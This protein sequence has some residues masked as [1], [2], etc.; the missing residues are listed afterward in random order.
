[1]AMDYRVDYQII[2]TAAKRARCRVNDMLALAPKNDPFYVGAPASVVKAQWFAGIYN[3]RFRDTQGA[4]LRRI[5]YRLVVEGDAT[6]A[7]GTPYEN[8]EQCWDYLNDASKAARY[9]GLVDADD[10]VDRRNPDP[11]IS[12]TGGGDVSVPVVY[13]DTPDWSLPSLPTRFELPSPGVQVYGYEYVPDNQPYLVEVWIEKT[14]QNDILAPLCR[15]LGANL[16]TSAGYQ[17]V[18]AALNLIRRAVSAD[19]PARVF[20]VSDFDPAGLHMPVS[21]ARQV[22]FW[23]QRRGLSL[24]IKLTPLALTRAQ[25]DEHGLPRT[26][27]KETD[28]RREGFELNHGTGA[29]ELDALEALRPGELEAL[30]RRAIA[31]Y[32]DFA[33][34]DRLL[35]S[36]AEAKTAA[37]E[38]W[39]N[40]YADYQAEKDAIETEVRATLERYQSNLALDLA[41]IAERAERLRRA[42]RMEADSFEPELPERPKPKARGTDKFQWVFD[43]ARD[44]VDQLN[45]YKH[46]SRGDS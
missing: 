24:D 1:M 25:A 41:P 29:V 8:T 13:V 27:I 17:S 42:V 36:E 4:H 15:E 34:R 6:R 3:S 5:H 19:K 33:L 11:V 30:A 2:K 46:H 37:E 21:V 22:E 35:K 18:T 32:R 43:A 7:D 39:R 45:A 10:F 44:Y 14:T 28:K 12:M 16:V 9:L 38:A 31:P 40:R 23:L 20:Y 26:P